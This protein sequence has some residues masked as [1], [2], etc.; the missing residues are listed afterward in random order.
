M[1]TQITCM[2]RGAKNVRSNPVVVTLPVQK[3]SKDGQPIFD[4][5]GKEV[6]L[7]KLVMKFNRG[8]CVDV[9]AQ[10]KKM[11]Y[12]GNVVAEA[13]G[14]SIEVYAGWMVHAIIGDRRY[15]GAFKSGK[16]DVGT[17]QKKK[18]G[19]KPAAA[20]ANKSM[21]GAPAAK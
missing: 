2:P 20:P 16:V 10:L 1:D 5:D 7:G 12:K 8:E 13:M 11:A 6:Y 15:I 9:A 14:T 3:M 17:G 19:P 21:E 18:P 4:K